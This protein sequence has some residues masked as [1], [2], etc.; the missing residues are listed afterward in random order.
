MKP[1]NSPDNLRLYWKAAAIFL[2]LACLVV[3]V[4]PQH[5]TP[6]FR[7]TGSDPAHA[8]WNIG[9]PIALFIYD[10]RSGLHVGP[11]AYVMLPFQL[12]LVAVILV[13]TRRA[14]NIPNPGA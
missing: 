1:S 4:F 12:L 13:V 7:Y 9:W 8:V 5:G 10:P 3:D 11:M 6:H 14:K 2:V